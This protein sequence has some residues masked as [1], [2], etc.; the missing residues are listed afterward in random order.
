MTVNQWKLLG[1][2]SYKRQRVG[3]EERE[4]S[5]AHKRWDDAGI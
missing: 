2:G 3:S 1:K 5:I 4:S